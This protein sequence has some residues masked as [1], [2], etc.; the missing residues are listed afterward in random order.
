MAYQ[1][2]FDIYESAT[3]Q[4]VGRIVQSLSLTAPIP[5]LAKGK[6]APTPPGSATLES[7]PI[8]LEPTPPAPVQ[9]SKD[10]STLVSLSAM[11]S[12]IFKFVLFGFDTEFKCTSYFQ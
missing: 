2:A 9:E 11:I 5:S 10:P 4:L 8:T 6:V 3:Q 7:G 1:L 12:R